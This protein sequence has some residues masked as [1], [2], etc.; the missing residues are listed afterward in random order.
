MA[1]ETRKELIDK[2]ETLVTGYNIGEYDFSNWEEE[3][4]DTQG[5]MATNLY[6]EDGFL[7]DLQIE[8]LEQI[9]SKYN[10]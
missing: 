4:L 8:K 9:Y 5:N 1:T 6:A 10:K 7:T 2:Y 3:F